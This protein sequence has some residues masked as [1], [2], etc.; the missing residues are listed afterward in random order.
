[1]FV[2]TP[3]TKD[4]ETDRERVPFISLLSLLFSYVHLA[5]APE[6]SEDEDEQRGPNDVRVGRSRQS[7]AIGIVRELPSWSQD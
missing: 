1:M 7:L 3:A 6:I 2:S 4:G 5:A